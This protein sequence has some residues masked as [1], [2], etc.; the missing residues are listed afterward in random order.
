MLKRLDLSQKSGQE[1]GDDGV[2]LVLQAGVQLGD[3]KLQLHHQRSRELLQ[4]LNKFLC[5]ML[6]KIASCDG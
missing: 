5:L 2:G 6:L 3:H 1:V 4:N